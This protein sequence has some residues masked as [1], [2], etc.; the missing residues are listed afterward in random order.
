MDRVTIA[1]GTMLYHGTD[2]AGDFAIPDGPCWFTLRHEDAIRWVGWSESLPQ[3]RERGL[4]RVLVSETIDDIDLVD[5]TALKRWEAVATAVCDDPEATSYAVANAFLKNGI[6]GWIGDR[7]IMLTNP[8]QALK[9]RE[10]IYL[11]PE[12]GAPSLK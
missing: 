1:K 4:G 12:Y 3:G 10:V 11:E 9:A 8:G 6:V 5:V 2:S 7:E